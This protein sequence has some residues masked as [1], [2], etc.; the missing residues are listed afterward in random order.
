[1]MNKLKKLVESEPDL[2]LVLSTSPVIAMLFDEEG[3]CIYMSPYWTKLTGQSYKKALGSGWLEYVA[4]KDQMQVQKSWIRSVR[5]LSDFNREFCVLAKDGIVCAR[6][7][8]VF[9]ESEKLW[10]GALWLK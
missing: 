4:P 8:I 9:G 7:K 10:G 5:S 1:M 6:A 3:E 2:G